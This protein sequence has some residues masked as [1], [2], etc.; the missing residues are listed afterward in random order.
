[1]KFKRM[2]DIYSRMVDYTI[3][4]TNEVN[5]FSVGSVMRSLYE[6][7]SIELEQFYI[8]TRENMQ[9]A[10][11][12]GVYGSFGFERKLSQ[13][14]YGNMRLEFHT[15]IQS[16]MTI[17]RGSK[18]SSSL[19]SYQQVYATTSEYYIP[20]GTVVAEIEV[21]C[22]VPG[23]MGNVPANTLDVMHAPTSNIKRV[24]N[25]SAFQTGQ[26]E[27]P[28]EEL[29]SRFNSYIKSLSRA[30]IPAL[31]YGTRTV[32]QVSGVY[33]SE[34]P[35]RVTIFAHD[36]NGDLPDD[37]RKMIENIMYHYRP[38]GIR[39]DVKPVTR[40][41]I[42]LSVDVVLSNKTAITNRFSSHIKQEIE[43]YLNNMQ[44]G[45][46]LILSDLSSTI[47]LI[48]KQLIYDVQFTNPT[49]NV[50]LKGSEVIRAGQ[51]MVNLK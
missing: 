33:I 7:L 39:V 37:V 51:V 22:L 16:T 13:K 34:T 3:T 44:T 27:E 2:S 17:S 4:S 14:A 29:R 45:Q 8:L 40:Q 1:M 5:D 49:K 18:F 42:D 25:P 11:E 28:V 21:T 19:K 32:P 48:D 47:K 41:A 24:Y 6:S 15:P 36:R 26:N 20:I 50:T 31:E 35:G 23:E 46:S 12:N 9:E 38:A 30:T 10:I 43:R